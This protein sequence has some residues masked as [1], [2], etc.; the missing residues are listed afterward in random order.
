MMWSSEFGL[1]WFWSIHWFF[2]TMFL[3]GVVLLIIWMTKTLDK[4]QLLNWII[5]LLVVGAL[6]S[7]LTVGGGMR[8]WKTMMDKNWDNFPGA[9][10]GK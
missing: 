4:K 7:L 1:S 9:V 3:I 8:G 6:G 5:I 2:A 10:G